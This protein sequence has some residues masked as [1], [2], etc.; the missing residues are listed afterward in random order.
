MNKEGIKQM[1]RDM[2]EVPENAKLLEVT[3]LEI[4]EL[5]NIGVFIFNKNK[6]GSELSSGMFMATCAAHERL[7]DSKNL[8]DE[9]Q[10]KAIDWMKDHIDAIVLKPGR[11]REAF[12]RELVIFTRDITEDALGVK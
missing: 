4:E 10:E 6:L 8:W 7:L 3:G 12:M 11:K 9:I 1:I 2:R 5:E